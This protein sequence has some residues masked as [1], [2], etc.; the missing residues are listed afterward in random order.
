LVPDIS[1]LLK[2]IQNEMFVRA[3]NT[4]NSRVSKITGIMWSPYWI[5]GTSFLFL[6]VRGGNVKIPSRR[7]ARARWL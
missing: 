7:E 6:G 2:A 3:K 5:T 1:A 4:Y